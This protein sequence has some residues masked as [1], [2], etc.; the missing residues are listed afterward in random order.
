MQFESV[1][2][3]LLYS[4]DLTS[5]RLQSDTLFNNTW[6]IIALMHHHCCCSPQLL[7]WIVMINNRFNCELWVNEHWH[8]IVRTLHQ[9]PSPRLKR[10]CSP[11][12]RLK[13]SWK[14][15]PSA[16]PLKQIIM[17]PLT[18]PPI[19]S[20]AIQCLLKIAKNRFHSPIIINNFVF[21]LTRRCFFCFLLLEIKRQFFL[22]L[23]LCCCVFCFGAQQWWRRRR[24]VQKI[25][26]LYLLGRITTKRFILFLLALFHLLLATSLK[27]LNVIY[28][29]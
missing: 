23:A 6:N 26:R 29:I 24:R 11:K 9:C 16:D 22:P 20:N 14:I 17:A 4:W 21:V 27:L 1:S 12:P 8:S 18:A 15:L 19:M 13:S 5:L 7:L 25:K 2:L 3:D 28:S 10:I